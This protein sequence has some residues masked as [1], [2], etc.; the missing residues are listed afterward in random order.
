[1]W[2]SGYDGQRRSLPCGLSP[3]GLSRWTA[4]P[5]CYWPRR[6]S[7]TAPPTRVLNPFY[8]PFI[9][10]LKSTV[11]DMYSRLGKMKSSCE[12]QKE[13]NKWVT[14]VDCIRWVF[15]PTGA[16][17]RLKN[18]INQP[19]RKSS[20]RS[21]KHS[22]YLQKKFK[23]LHCYWTNASPYVQPSC[24]LHKNDWWHLIKQKM[25]SLGSSQ[26][27]EVLAEC[28]NLTTFEVVTK[29]TMTLYQL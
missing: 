6:T 18:N 29:F 22:D 15:S 11:R 2:H 8:T 25:D 1:M 12:M 19:G 23:K 17:L 7:A 27:S 9:H 24:Y 14:L 4:K 21:W 3:A 26:R 28:T 10:F 20:A 13:L 16:K 5:C